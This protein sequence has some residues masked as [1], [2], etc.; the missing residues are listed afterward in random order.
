MCNAEIGRGAQTVLSFVW[1]AHWKSGW[2]WATPTRSSV[3]ATHPQH[4]RRTSH[5]TRGC[6]PTRHVHA[7]YLPYLVIIATVAPCA[8]HCGHDVC[9][10]LSTEPPISNQRRVVAWAKKGVSVPVSSPVIT[11][12]RA[13]TL[14][15]KVW[16]CASFSTAAK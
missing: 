14:A 12:L 6:D 5:P 15:T 9:C 3:K 7:S 8:T 1:R 10:R 4:H 11:N 2:S 16:P 13:M